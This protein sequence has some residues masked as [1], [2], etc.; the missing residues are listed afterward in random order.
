[1]PQIAG[2]VAWADPADLPLGRYRRLPGA[3]YL[4]GVR[5]Q[6]QAEPAGYLDRADVRA[7]L[8][9]VGA[10]GLAFDLVVRADQLGECARLAADLPSVR[11]VLDHL[12]KPPVASGRSQ[13]WR[14]DLARLAACPN[15]SAKLSGLVTEADWRTWTAADLR[16]F[17]LAALDLFGAERL[18]FGSDWPV[19]LLAASYQGV[20]DTM[21]D[22]LGDVGDADRAAIFGGTAVAFYQLD[23]GGTGVSSPLRNA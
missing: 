22:L 13:P 9:A 5:A 6:V 20:L 21:R 19:C 3:E 7:G 11:F 4:V 18:M 14:D 8:L 23:P 2:V 12:G 16:P 1:M 10:A 17:V 15:V